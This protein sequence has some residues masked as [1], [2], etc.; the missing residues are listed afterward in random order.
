MDYRCP[1]CARD[2][3]SRKLSQAV[4]AKWEM[5]CRYCGGRIR[6]NVH[7]L[8]LKVVVLCFGAFAALALLAWWRQDR[9]L[10]FAALCVGGAGAVAL[11]ILERTYLRTW[12][13]Y[14]PH[15]GTTGPT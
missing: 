9:F 14:L 4:I 12:A 7:P 2:L 5:K 6:L 3:A 10:T 8:E 1:I 11:P 13:R 15:A